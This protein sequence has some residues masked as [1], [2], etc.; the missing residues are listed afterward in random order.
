MSELNSGFRRHEGSG[1]LVPEEVSREREVWTRDDLRLI[2]RA[3]KLLTSRG[4]QV[5]FAC[6]DKRCADVKITRVHGLAGDYILRCNHKD[7]VFQ[8]AF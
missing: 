4:I 8:R 6:T 3:T 2:D 7:R 1:L 5:M